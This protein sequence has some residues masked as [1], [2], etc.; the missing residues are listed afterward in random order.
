MGLVDESTKDIVNE[1]E[2]NFPDAELLF[3]TWKSQNV[4]D[5]SCKTIQIDYPSFLKKKDD[6]Q[7]ANYSDN[8]LHGKLMFAFLVFI[9]LVTIF[10]FVSY[11]KV[12]LPEAASEHGS[13]Y[14][15]LFFISLSQISLAEAT[16][17]FFVSPFFITIF[18]MIFPEGCVLDATPIRSEI[19]VGIIILS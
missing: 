17:L 3:C 12:L 11:T 15:T 7:I 8:D 1:Y 10:S 16:T 2:N 18:S 4:E 19:A 13:T 5:I 9:Y 6:S 14:D